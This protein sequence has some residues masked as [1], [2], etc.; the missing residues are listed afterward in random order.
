MRMLGYVPDFN[1]ILEG[2]RTHNY[3]VVGRNGVNA[4][5]GEFNGH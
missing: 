1:A 3:I 5:N 4:P 2:T